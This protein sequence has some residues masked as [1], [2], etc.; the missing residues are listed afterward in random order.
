[1]LGGDGGQ[2]ATLSRAGVCV[3]WVLEDLT[4]TCCDALTRSSSPG[5]TKPKAAS[6]PTVEKLSNSD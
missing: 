4:K 2:A 1:M 3:G 5:Q 6:D